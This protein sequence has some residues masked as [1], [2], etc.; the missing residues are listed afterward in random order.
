MIYPRE[1]R[2]T[3]AVSDSVLENELFICRISTLGGN[4][5]NFTHRAQVRLKQKQLKKQTSSD[6][7]QKINAVWRDGVREC[8]VVYNRRKLRAFLEY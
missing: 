4:F 5:S 8:L 3:L 7:A 6:I 2:A 1:Y